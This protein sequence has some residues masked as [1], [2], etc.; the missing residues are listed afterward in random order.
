[1]QPVISTSRQTGFPHE[2]PERGFSLVELMIAMAISL[3]LLSAL[4]AIFVNSSSSAR[5]LANA[6]SMID[7][8]RLVIQLLQNDLEH[9]GYWGGY[10]P[11]W[12]DLTASSVP[13]DTPTLVPNPCQNYTTWDSNYVMSLIGVPVQA[14]QTLPVGAGCVGA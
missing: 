1:M 9:A 3:F 11:Q 8:G 13:G 2:R 14:D 10:I 12:D 5:E 4:V 7:N 6:N